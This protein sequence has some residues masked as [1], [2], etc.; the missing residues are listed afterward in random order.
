MKTLLIIYPHWPPSNLAGVHR[1]RLIANFLDD[2]GWKAVVLTVEQKYY[3]Q[4]PDFDLCKLV[5]QQ[6][7]VHYTKAYRI[8]KPRIIGDIGL[9]AFNY[10]K[11]QALKIISQQ[12]IDFIWIPIPSFYVALLGRILHN[13]TKIPYG[14]D[15]IDPWV[16][17]ISNRR[18]LR[19]ILSNI[20]AQILEPIAVKKASLISGVS[21][22]Y[23]KPMLQRN[24]KNK[25][26]ETIA[27]PYGFD[28]KDHNVKIYNLQYPWNNYPN[29]IPIIYAGAV[30]PL[31]GYFIELLFK[32]IK[33]LLDKNQINKNTKLFFVGTG[34]Y[35]HKSIEQYAS[36]AGITENV[37][38]LRQR[39]PF[40]H[41]LNFL[42]AA[43]GVMVIGS[44]QKHY[45]ASKIFQ[46]LL[47]Q[48]PVFAIMHHKSTIVEILKQ[49][50]A[51]NYLVEYFEHQNQDELQNKIK[52]TF[53]NFVNN[54]ALWQP[55][56]SA[57]DKY[58]AKQSAKI[59]VEAI[60]KNIAQ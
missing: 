20:V 46:A 41:I 33:N 16:R 53:E 9:R 36:E 29:S 1:P 26:I 45:T 14:I 3:E 47:S 30:L 50:N 55:N 28:P 48:Q 2:F 7:E 17:N 27:M 57:L 51:N 32:S 35:T 5:N 19:A 42:S 6:I 4:P 10:L 44:T 56:L 38:E 24:F 15:Y 34:N 31:S 23:F 21:Y 11:H 52:Q 18:N 49:C 13:K 37:V 8:T 60:E 59:L 22:E 54:S 58:S 25:K 12:K 39:F 43:K 40:L